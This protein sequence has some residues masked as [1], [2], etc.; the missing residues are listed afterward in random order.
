MLHS[1]KLLVF[2]C[3]VLNVRVVAQKGTSEFIDN[4]TILKPLVAIIYPEKMHKQVAGG[5]YKINYLKQYNSHYLLMPQRVESVSAAA[6]ELNGCINKH[7]NIDKQR[8]YLLIIDEAKTNPFN[9]SLDRTV[10]A[11]VEYFQTVYDTLAVINIEE[12]ADKFNSKYTWGIHVSNIEE[13]RRRDV[14]RVSKFRLGFMMGMNLQNKF[15]SDTAYLPPSLMKYGVLISKNLNERLSLNFSLMG[16]VKIPNQK[17]LQSEIQGQI[18]PA[19]GSSQKIKVEITSHIIFQANIQASYQ[20]RLQ[21]ESFRP[22]VS[23]GASVTSITS[24]Y[25]KIN[26]YVNISTIQSGNQD[27]LGLN[28]DEL[29][30]FSSTNILPLTGAGFEYKLSEKASFIF[31]TDVMFQVKNK[32]K[33]VEVGSGINSISVTSGFLFRIGKKPKYYYNYVQSK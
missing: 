26:R 8:I 27:A 32:V 18:N 4:G 31:N 15:N 7:V 1:G 30:F 10:F 9:D 5:V 24:A 25:Q 6:R 29:P 12:L 33:G 19:N 3:L 28:E 23:V 17:K 22:Y 14:N 13:T 16:S 20:F 21:N 2:I 11:A